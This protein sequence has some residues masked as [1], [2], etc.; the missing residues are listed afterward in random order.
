MIAKVG[1]VLQFATLFSVLIGGLGL[2]VALL[3][4]REQMKTQVF[5][6]LSA[7]YDALLQS[8]S[9]GV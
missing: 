1:L 7:R 4:N 2:A 6:A 8:A 9:P 5:L 3:I